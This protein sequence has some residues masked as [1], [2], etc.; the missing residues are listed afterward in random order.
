[1]HEINEAFFNIRTS[2]MEEKIYRKYNRKYKSQIIKKNFDHLSTAV[3]A[4]NSR[5]INTSKEKYLESFFVLPV[6]EYFKLCKI[7]FKK[8]KNCYYNRNYL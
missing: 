6:N 5:F 3:N 8:T 1:M 2:R 4:Y 7:Y